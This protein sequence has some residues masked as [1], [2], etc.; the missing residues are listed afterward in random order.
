M[1][2]KMNNIE[3]V[4]DS[5]FENRK[6]V[7]AL[8]L[9]DFNDNIEHDLFYLEKAK[10]RVTALYEKVMELGNKGQQNSLSYTAYDL[11]IY[12]LAE[13]IQK[14]EVIIYEKYSY[15]KNSLVPQITKEIEEAKENWSKTYDKALE[16]MEIH[17]KGSF[18]VVDL[19]RGVLKKYDVTS[20]SVDND[21]VMNEAYKSLKRYISA[22]ESDTTTRK[23]SVKV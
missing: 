7:L 22:Y 1:K 4:L 14:M 18:D 6:E 21:E 2:E 10:N 11:E 8:P 3:G 20:K 5:M 19:M 16:I 12:E 23:K 15:Y 13:K 17:E 9:K